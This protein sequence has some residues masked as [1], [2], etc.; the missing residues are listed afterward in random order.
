[1]E[2]D[3]DIST[4]HVDFLPNRIYLNQ[5]TQ[6]KNSEAWRRAAAADASSISVRDRDFIKSGGVLVVSVAESV[7]SHTCHRVLHIVFSLP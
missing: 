6:I 3:F 1:M 7:P 5:N 2:D 4:D